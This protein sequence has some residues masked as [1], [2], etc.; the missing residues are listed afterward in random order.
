MTV[1][2]TCFYTN[3]IKAISKLQKDLE[4]GSNFGLAK[5]HTILSVTRSIFQL[6]QNISIFI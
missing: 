4:N 1:N 2:S 5:D 6:L 3:N